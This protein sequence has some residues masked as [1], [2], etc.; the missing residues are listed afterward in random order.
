MGLWVF[1]RYIMGFLAGFCWGFWQVFVGVFGGG[2]MGFL[3]DLSENGGSLSSLRS[4][5]F[6]GGRGFLAPIQKWRSIPKYT[7]LG[8]IR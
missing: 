7:Q 3:A 1:C 8:I 5:R 2:L 4:Q 6:F